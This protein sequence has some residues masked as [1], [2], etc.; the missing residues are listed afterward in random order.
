M[1]LIT[2]KQI[3]IVGG[4]PGGLMLARL[5]QMKGATVK[6][7]ERDKNKTIRQQ[8]ATLDLHEESGLKAMTAAGLMEQ[9]QLHYRPGA[10]KLRVVDE[11]AT[12]L[13]DEHTHQDNNVSHQRPEIDRGPLRDILMASLL[14]DTITWDAQFASM[15]TKDNGWKLHF[16]NGATALADIVIAAD[17]ANSLI[18]PWLSDIAPIYSGVTAVEGNIYQAKKNAPKLNALLQGGKVFALGKEKSLIM[19]AKGDGTLSFYA[20]FKA[21]ENWLQTSNI[22]FKDPQSAFDWFLHV[23]ADWHPIW[24]ELFQAEDI[25]FVP[26]P[27]YHYPL[28]QQWQTQSNLTML[29]DAA[30]RMP[31]YAGEGVNMALLDALELSECLTSE[32]FETI[33][34]AIAAYEKQMLPRAAAATEMSV[35]NT[36]LLHG[37]NAMNSLFAIFQGD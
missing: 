36:A 32:Q 24:Q 33:H 29:G 17:G 14:P 16:K 34:D 20:G 22:N 27:M 19:S 6:V 26:R 12:I 25:S 37:E 28:D 8:G 1:M 2:N 13:L 3:A 11:N 10:E 5:L 35:A 30:H 21:V 23:Y 18:R 4:G 31:P 9:F 7:Y 15:E